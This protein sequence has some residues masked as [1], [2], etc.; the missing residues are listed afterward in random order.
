MKGVI[1]ACQ[2]S[3]CLKLWLWAKV[4]DKS[5]QLWILVPPTPPHNHFHSFQ[6]QQHHIPQRF[7]STRCGAVGV[8]TWWGGSTWRQGRTCPRLFKHYHQYC[9]HY[10]N[11]YHHC[12]LGDKAGLVQGYTSVII[13][14]VIFTV[15][16]IIID[17]LGTR[18]DFSKVIQALSSILSS[19]L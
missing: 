17:N 18:Q 15:I 11:N 3:Y 5:K 4:L 1:L 12:Q 14:I 2:L 19:L 10:S 13:D 16:I 6:H 8:R 9:H 7:A